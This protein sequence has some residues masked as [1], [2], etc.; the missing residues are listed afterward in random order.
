MAAIGAKCTDF[1][2]RLRGGSSWISSI[3][4]SSSSLLSAIPMPPNRGCCGGPLCIS[5]RSSV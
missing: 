3:I 5:F 2:T 4:S 1:W